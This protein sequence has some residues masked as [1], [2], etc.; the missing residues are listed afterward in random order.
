MSGKGDMTMDIGYG[1]NVRFRPGQGG[2]YGVL[3]NFRAQSPVQ[4]AG[5][6]FFWA[7]AFLGATGRFVLRNCASNTAFGEPDSI[8]PVRSEKF[9]SI[10][11]SRFTN[12]SYEMPTVSLNLSL[13]YEESTGQKG[14]RWW[15]R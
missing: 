10:P 4:H 2:N 8:E 15:A 5:G 11:H 14:E 1:G 13:I 12:P 3:W 6:I 9:K 7:N